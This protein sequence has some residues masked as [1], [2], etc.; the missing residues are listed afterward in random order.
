MGIEALH[1]DAAKFAHD[2]PEFCAF[3]V[4]VLRGTFR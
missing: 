1:Q 2:D 3:I 4:G